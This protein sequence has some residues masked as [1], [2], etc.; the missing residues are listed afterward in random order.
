M[1]T[2]KTPYDYRFVILLTLLVMLLASCSKEDVAEQPTP[3]AAKTGATIVEEGATTNGN[4]V[5]T[6]QLPRG[7][8]QC[9]SA[10]L[11]AYAGKNDLYTF[12]TCYGY[13]GSITLEDGRTFNR[14]ELGVLCQRSPGE[15]ELILDREAEVAENFGSAFGLGNITACTPRTELRL[16]KLLADNRPNRILFATLAGGG[17]AIWGVGVWASA[18]P[19]PTSSAVS[20]VAS[21]TIYTVYLGAVKKFSNYSLDA[22][23]G[24]FAAGAIIAVTNVKEWLVQAFRSNNARN[25]QCPTSKEVQNLMELGQL[26]QD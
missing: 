12:E 14:F 2:S 4:L 18:L 10:G 23:G 3:P 19:D 25:G 21:A 26:F 17:T 20:A 8:P 13:D 7:G 6:Q 15:C 11:G 1:R 16:R 5:T 9:E 24:D 22:A